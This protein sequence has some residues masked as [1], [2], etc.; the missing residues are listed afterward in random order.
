MQVTID[1]TRAMLQMQRLAIPE[2]DIAEVALRL[3]TWLT[4]L[5][6]IEAELGEAMNAVD[7]VPPV[8]P[9]EEF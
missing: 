6:E 2:T 1:Q 9:R 7:P 5:E 4:A 3:S 8:F